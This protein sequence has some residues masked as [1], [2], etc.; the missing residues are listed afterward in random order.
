[1]SQ[2]GR[3]SLRSEL[4]GQIVVL[5]GI[6][7]MAWPQACCGAHPS[8]LGSM[9]FLAASYR[10]NDDQGDRNSETWR[11][12]LGVS[13]LAESIPDSVAAVSEVWTQFALGF[14]EELNGRPA[15]ALE[16][17]EKAEENSS[18]PNP[19]LL[20]RRAACLLE[21]RRH[22]EAL[23]AAQE[24]IALDSLSSEALWNV[25]ASLVALRRPD[26]AVAPLRRM[27]DLRQDRRA[28]DVLSRVLEQEGRY[29]EAIEPLSELVRMTP[30]SPHQLERRSAI[31]TRL[32][33]YD[34][35]L[36]DYWAILEIS[37]EHPVIQ[38]QM[39]SLLK[40]LHRGE[41]LI[42]LYQTLTAKM[43]RRIDLRW[44]LVEA[45][46]QSEAWEQSEAELWA[47]QEMDPT[48][49]LP[50]LQL[51]LV[52]YRTGH[53]QRALKFIERADSLEIKPE[54]IERWRMRINFAQ[55]HPD[56]ALASA[57]R[58]AELVPGSAEAWRIRSLCLMK[59]G[60]LQ[61][62]LLSIEPWAR[63]VETDP[64]PFLLG[65][66]VCRELDLLD[67]TITMM[68]NAAK[69]A[70]TDSRILLDYAVSLEAADRIADAEEVLLGLLKREPHHAQALNFLGYMWTDRGL[71]L[72]QAEVLIRKALGTEPDNPAFLD[73]MGWLWYK[74]ADLNQAEKWLARAVDMGGDHPEIY[75][76]LAQVKKEQGKVAEARQVLELGLKR[77][78]QDPTLRNFLLGLGDEG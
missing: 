31:L 74:K 54:F 14:Q 61:E 4:L 11:V 34:E 16:Y 77:N 28:L 17:Y 22:A 24:A 42:N 59:V 23:T 60:R 40:Q 1:M 44:K 18:W 35:A 7:L 3:G 37:P 55:G 15:A 56:A 33:R 20:T 57:T 69:R 68:K 12:V 2:T 25:A 6:V 5:C 50:L 73:S 32:G 49:G 29:E 8:S 64:E 65:A 10:R 38:K 66:A 75:C 63:L 67:Q 21:L 52:A 36:R 30:S 43:P 19:E 78:P 27:I 53:P 72:S 51:G 41:E 71:H 62:A 13:E 58:L 9:E 48:S 46:I 76:H 26:E 70:P 39:V 47:L 45:L